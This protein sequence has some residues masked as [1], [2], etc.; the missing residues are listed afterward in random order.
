MVPFGESDPVAASDSDALDICVYLC[1]SVVQLHGSGKENENDWILASASWGAS[2]AK[3]T[4]DTSEIRL[5]IK[6][7]ATLR[8]QR[9]VPAGCGPGKVARIIQPPVSSRIHP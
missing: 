5:T 6:F 7:C 4:E 1:A 9:I 8:F 2:F 3:A